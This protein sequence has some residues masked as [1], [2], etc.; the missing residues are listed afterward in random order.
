MPSY[1]SCRK[2]T[3]ADIIKVHLER[4]A[5]KVKSVVQKSHEDAARRS[6][7]VSV[8]A[9]DDFDKLLSCKFTPRY[10]KVKKY[11]YYAGLIVRGGRCITQVPVN[12]HVGITLISVLTRCYL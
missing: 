4:Q 6:F 5:L 11:I 1:K 3:S 8:E 10:V 7:K 9:S 2:D 12:C